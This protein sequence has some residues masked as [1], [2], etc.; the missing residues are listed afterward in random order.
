MQGGK[1]V[2][3]LNL[4]G[5]FLQFLAIYYAPYVPKLGAFAINNLN[6]DGLIFEQ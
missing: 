2:I 5:F 4:K 3:R 1:W 6:I